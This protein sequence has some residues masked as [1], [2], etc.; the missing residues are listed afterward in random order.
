MNTESLV[1][2]DKVMDVRSVPC[3]IK[4]PAIL[5]AWFNLA[6]GDYFILVNHHDPVPLRNQLEKFGAALSW[7]YLEA[8]PE[9]VRIKIQ[10]LAPVAPMEMD[11]PCADH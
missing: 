4:H 7:E 3:A 11:N 1:G 8:G 9:I 10:K 5:K 2:S 6:V